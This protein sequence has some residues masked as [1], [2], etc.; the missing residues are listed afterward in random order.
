[1]AQYR[2]DVRHAAQLRWHRRMGGQ[3]MLDDL[4]G[5]SDQDYVRYDQK[6]STLVYRAQLVR[7]LFGAGAARLFMRLMK[8]DPLVARRVMQSP[9]SRLRR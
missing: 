9:K 7:D 3:P 8:V 2:P 6:T 5:G 4:G 1:M